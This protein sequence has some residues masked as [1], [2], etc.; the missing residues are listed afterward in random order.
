MKLPLQITTRHVSLSE[1]AVETIKQKA[2]KLET[3][4]NQI[5]ACRVMVEAPHRH[6]S[7]GQLFNV[8]LDITVPGGELVVKKEPHQDIY[9]SIRDAFDAARRQLQSY[10]KKRRGDVK[11]HFEAMA[12]AAAVEPAID[13]DTLGMD[14]EFGDEMTTPAQS[15]FDKQWE[16]MENSVR[17]H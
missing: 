3:F 11:T 15:V 17:L 14:A 13:D 5:I 8:R 4:Y 1:T 9:V 12:A 2:S 10:A 7:Q 16:E 6:K